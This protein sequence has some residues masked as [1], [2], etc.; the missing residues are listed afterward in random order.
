[1]HVFHASSSLAEGDPPID[2]SEIQKEMRRD[3]D[4]SAWIAENMHELVETYGI[5]LVA[6]RN[7]KVVSVK[8]NLAKLFDDLTVHSVPVQSVTIE[9]LS[10]PE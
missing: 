10:K 7:K 5:Q 3:Q 8:K 2:S 6:V 9:V 4:D 1:M